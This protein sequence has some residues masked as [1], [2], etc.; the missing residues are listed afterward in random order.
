MIFKLS[1][2]I[3]LQSHLIFLIILSL[4]IEIKKMV[5]DNNSFYIFLK[6]CIHEIKKKVKLMKNKKKIYIFDFALK[7]KK[8]IAFVVF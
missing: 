8:K 2:I 6:N 5:V 4:S 1:K 3:I 7:M